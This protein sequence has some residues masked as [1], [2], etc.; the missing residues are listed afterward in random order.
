MPQ[1]DFYILS[2]ANMS[3][4]LFACRLTQK[5]YSLGERVLLLTASEQQTAEVDSL[6][7]TFDEGSFVP[8]QR[9]GPKWQGDDVTPVSIGEAPLPS[10]PCSV[11]VNLAADDASNL[12]GQTRIAEIIAANDSDKAAGR[13]RFAN[14]K[15]QGITPSVHN[16]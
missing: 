10:W 2:N 12:T 5:A 1:V 15:A 14:W 7:W 8:H 13:Q 6:L 4:E 3:A 16:L 11:L 9:L